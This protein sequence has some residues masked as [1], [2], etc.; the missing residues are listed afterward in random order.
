M[1]VEE[2]KI[3]LAAKDRPPLLLPVAA[4]AAVVGLRTDPYRC[5]TTTVGGQQGGAA[6]F[7]FSAVTRDNE[8]VENTRE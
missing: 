8:G 4:S 6:H 1:E 7:V 3:I 2:M 5:K